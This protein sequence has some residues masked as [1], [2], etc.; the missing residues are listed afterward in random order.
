[1]LFSLSSNVYIGVRYSDDL[2][3]ALESMNKVAVDD[4]VSM[5]LANAP[6][7]QEKLGLYIASISKE[8]LVT[9][10]LIVI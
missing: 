1:M 4:T 6:G 9:F 3:Y 8:T 5:L 7:L 10:S 2:F